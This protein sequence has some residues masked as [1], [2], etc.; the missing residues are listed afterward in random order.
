MLTPNPL[1]VLIGHYTD[2]QGGTGCTVVLCPG[3]ATPAVEVR[4]GAPCSRET[5][6]FRPGAGVDPRRAHGVLLAGGSV[7][8]LAATEGV[9]RFLRQHD[10]GLLTAHAL[11]PIV[12]TAGLYDLGVAAAT[13]H[14]DAAAGYGACAAAT[15]L[16]AAEGTV[17][18]GTGATVGKAGGMIRCTKGGLGI[19]TVSPA[20]LGTLQAIVA[21]NAFGEV[22]DP[23]TGAIV[24]GVRAGSG[25]GFEPT[26]AILSSPTGKTAL[27]NTA[28]GVVVTDL[29][30]T[31]EEATELARA[32]HDGLALAIRPAHT[33]VDGDTMFVLATG[34]SPP[35][36]LDMGE[37]VRL[38]YAT[39]RVVADA[40]L[41]AVR[42]ATGLGGIPA[43]R[44]V[45]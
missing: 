27:G 33:R 21:V 5:D 42:L 4:G 10:I 32:A 38:A 40:I 28:V 37:T 3:G 14:P 15:R 9:V 41:R 24:A 8:G 26:A 11:V 7:F 44:D 6:I 19:A 13:A 16:P 23:D 25:R 36:G 35:R 31:R 2:L 39:S 34:S 29:S 45:A 30:L 12:A 20:A 43:A 17:G 1:G 22:V 18:A